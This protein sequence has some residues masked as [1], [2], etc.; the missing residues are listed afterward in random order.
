MDSADRERKKA[1]RATEQRAARDA[2]P[3]PDEV[4]QSLFAHVGRAVDQ[5]GCDHTLKAT[6]AWITQRG[7]A[8]EPVI[9]WLHDNGGY[10]DCEVVANAGDHWRQ[11]TQPC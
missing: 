11:T 4:L 10:C 7:A 9:A 3:L 8:R 2:F 1:W 6:D 5:D